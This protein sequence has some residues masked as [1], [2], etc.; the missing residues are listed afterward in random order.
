MSPT[1]A[2]GSLFKRPGMLVTATTNKFFA[3]VLSAQFKSAATGRPRV[4]LNLVPAAPARPLG[5][6]IIFYKYSL[7]DRY[8]RIAF[9]LWEMSEL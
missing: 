2:A 5:L 6:A 1:L 8:L 4:I 7:Q 9:Y 3:P